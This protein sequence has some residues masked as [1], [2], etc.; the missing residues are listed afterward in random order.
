MQKLK[1]KPKQPQKVSLS[2]RIDTAILAKLKVEAK[3]YRLSVSALVNAIL[4]NTR[5]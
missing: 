1:I 4:N 5:F 2:V 3:K